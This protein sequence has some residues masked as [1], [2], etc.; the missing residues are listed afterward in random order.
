M[1]NSIRRVELAD[2][3]AIREIYAP[4]VSDSATSFELVVPDLAEIGRRIEA[5][6]DRYPWLVFERGRRILGYAYASSHRARWAYQWSV[7]VSVYVHPE[8]HRYGVGRALYTALFGLLRRQGYVN[9]YAGIT[10]PNPSSVGLHES[11]GF[12][13]IGVFQRIGFKFDRWHDVAWQHLPL[14]ET[15]QSVS[16]PRPTAALW[17]EPS[18]AEML[19]AC[20]QSVR[21]G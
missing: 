19:D 17:Q 11:L 4:F 13:P 15:P 5:Q 8:A 12:V 9:A 21:L 16:E 14:V 2:A 18:V 6:R 1:E 20:A 7:E 10:L 3:P